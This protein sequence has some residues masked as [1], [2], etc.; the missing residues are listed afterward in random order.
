MKFIR[1]IITRNMQVDTESISC[2]CL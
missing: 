2:N 1:Q